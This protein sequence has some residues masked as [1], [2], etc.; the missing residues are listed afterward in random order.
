MRLETLRRA[1]DIFNILMLTEM[2]ASS[3]EFGCAP[4]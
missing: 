3:H 4:G 1:E 2:D